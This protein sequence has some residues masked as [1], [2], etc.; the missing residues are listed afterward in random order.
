M[1]ASLIHMVCKHSCMIVRR[2]PRGIKQRR[3]PST[4]QFGDWP[5]QNIGARGEV[6]QDAVCIHDGIAATARA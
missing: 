4:Q 3:R 5:T 1:S 2:V 6:V